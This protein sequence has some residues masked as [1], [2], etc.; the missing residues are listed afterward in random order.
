VFNSFEPRF[1]LYTVLDFHKLSADY[2][3]ALLRQIVPFWLKHSRDEQC[4]GYFDYL[5]DTGQV[6]EGD[7][8]VTAQAQQ[9]WAF[10]WL[11]NK[12]DGQPA[13]LEHARH[14]AVF[15]SQFAHDETLKAYGQLDRRGRSVAPSNDCLA[16]CSLVMAY[17]QLHRATKDD[18]WAMLAKQTFSTLFQDWTNT[19][20][21]Q[22]QIV[23][24]FRQQCH[25]SE[26]VLLLKT[27]L[28]IQSL[29]DEETWKENIE[30]VLNVLLRE[31]LDRRTDTLREYVLPEG[32][33]FNTPD[34]RRLNVGLT[35][36]AIGFLLDLCAESGNRKLAMQATTW[37]LRMCEL[38]WSE[39]TLGL[40]QY[41]DLKN[42]PLIFPEWS[43]K[44][45]WVQVEAISTLAKSYFQTRH[46]ECPKWINRIHDFTFQY[47]PDPKHT[48][49]HVAVG[50]NN[51]P[52]LAAKAI[53]PIGCF[54]LIR[55]LA[56]TAQT[57]TKCAQLQ[58]VGRH[59]RVN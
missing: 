32:S 55:C 53:A 14:G 22:A 33:F 24:G 38:A 44:W 25:L 36:Q 51:Q 20:T 47:F 45:A 35:F 46:P 29:L 30:T 1:Y 7:K 23:G 54:S 42:Q 11:Y 37:S 26:P 57:L 28:E 59:I 13:W 12:F 10:A 3:Q 39:L 9:V 21:E 50:Q 43:Q 58:P 31:F 2:Q 40:N 27:L 56:E 5:T 18:E 6:I 49:W 15:L 16:D 41:V 4:G 19:H 17:A 8:F 48:G 34:G 52:L